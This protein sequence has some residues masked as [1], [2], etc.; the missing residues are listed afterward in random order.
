MTRSL[1]GL[2]T[3]TL[4]TSSL[5]DKNKYLFTS[6]TCAPVTLN[7]QIK[8]RQHLIN[9]FVTTAGF[10]VSLTVAQTDENVLP[11]LMASD[12]EGRAEQA[13]PAEA[14]GPEGPTADQWKGREGAT[15]AHW[16]QESDSS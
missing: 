2:M 3:A 5:T 4:N 10:Q 12:R 6:S 8:H 1:W 14:R 11:F 16:P 15:G 7:C 13:S 9:V